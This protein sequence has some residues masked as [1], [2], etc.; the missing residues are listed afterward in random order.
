MYV[1]IV[2]SNAFNLN[3]LFFFFLYERDFTA[4]IADDNGAI[5]SLHRL[6]FAQTRK[7]GLRW[8]GDSI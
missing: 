3:K 8:M 2:I 6:S 4:S 1:D 5:T 7:C